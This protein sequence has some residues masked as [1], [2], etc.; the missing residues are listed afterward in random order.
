M[1]FQY[2][3]ECFRQDMAI[4]SWVLYNEQEVEVVGLDLMLIVPLRDNSHDFANAFNLLDQCNFA[5]EVHHTTH[6]NR[7]QEQ[8]L[9]NS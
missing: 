7:M 2:L 1:V 4:V 5:L 3:I 9:V 8:N 6:G